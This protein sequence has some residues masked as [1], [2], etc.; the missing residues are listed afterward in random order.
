[1]RQLISGLVAAAAVVTVSAAP[2]MACGFSSG[3]GSCGPVVVASPCGTPAYA[4]IEYGYSM[5][6]GAAAFE[7]LPD[8]TQYYY[9][10]QGPVFSGPGNFAPVP[11]YS[12]RAVSGWGGSAYDYGYRGGVYADAFT[13]RY[14]GAPA[15]RG[16]AIYRYRG[17]GHY[18][19]RHH[20][21]YGMH[22]YGMHRYGMHRH[23]MGHGHMMRAH[24]GMPPRGMSQGYGRHMQMH[25][26]Y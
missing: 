26:P 13:H 19:W 6:Y 9:V 14:A 12:T 2:A 21:H 7:R 16:P 1:M 17:H 18:G 25:R 11:T 3:C 20:G 10:N 15:W 4:P 23:G 24:Y 22:R 8:P 5:G